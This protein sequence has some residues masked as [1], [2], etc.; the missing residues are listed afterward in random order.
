MPRSVRV[1]GGLVV[2]GAVG[3]SVGL[4][5]RADRP[6]AR[7]SADPD[8]IEVLGTRLV[9]SAL[10]GWVVAD[11]APDPAPDRWL[12]AA[13]AA[14]TDLDGPVAAARTSLRD[15]DSD[16]AWSSALALVTALT[17]PS[18]DMGDRAA[19]ASEVATRAR[20]AERGGDAPWGAVWLRLA[21][22]GDADE[23]AAAR[24]EGYGGHLACTDLPSSATFGPNGA[25]VFPLRSLVASRSSCGAAEPLLRSVLESPDWRGPEAVTEV[26]DLAELVPAMGTELRGAVRDRLASWADPSDGQVA[27]LRLLAEIRR[28]RRILELPEG[29][30]DAVEHRLA[31]QLASQGRLPDQALQAPSSFDA[32]AVA[33]VVLEGDDHL[34][35]EAT[36]SVA[37]ANRDDTSGLDEII[38]RGQ[39]PTCTELTDLADD[40]PSERWTLAALVLD[41]MVRAERGA[42]RGGLDLARERREIDERPAAERA[43]RTLGLLLAQ[44]DRS[45]E[46]PGDLG[47]T[48][49]IGTSDDGFD[50]LVSALAADVTGACAAVAAVRR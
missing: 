45:T 28:A 8:P 18:A 17:F 34:A 6:E 19:V 9:P 22:L 15:A 11:L 42:C 5:G 21:L 25:L 4:A 33:L 38:L 2:V 1:L 37:V 35:L 47:L 12:Y 36:R 26:V 31:G 3:L 48:P 14:G 46:P 50:V 30:S 20:S 43:G 10:G 44:C 13:L 32:L 39:V 29:W 40:V 49:R 24:I 41:Q 27:D 7:R 16:L 23:G